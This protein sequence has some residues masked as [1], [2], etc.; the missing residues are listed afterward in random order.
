MPDY[1]TFDELKGLQQNYLISP[2][3]AYNGVILNDAQVKAYNCYT[4]DLNDCRDKQTR[5]L[6]LD[7]RHKYFCLC[8]GIIGM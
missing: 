3:K 8:I 5:A 7:N 4:Q 1:L 2:Y 6:L